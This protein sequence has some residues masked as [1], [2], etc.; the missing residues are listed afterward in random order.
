MFK[1]V[2]FFF[3]LIVF[4][5]SSKAEVV[6]EIIVNGNERISDDTVIMFTEISNGKFLDEDKLNSILKNLYD[7]GFFKD[8]DISFLNNKLVIKIVENPIIESVII[9]GIKAKKIKEPIIQNLLLKDRSSFNKFAVKKDEDFIIRFLKDKGYYF[10]KIITSI[11]DLG[12]NKISLIY[13]VEMGEKAKISKITFLGNKFFKD[14]KLRS[15]IITEEYKFWKFI[16]GKKFLNQG[17]IEFDKT[18]LSNFYKNEGFYKVKIDSTYANYLGGNKF[19]LIYNINSG[20]KFYFNNLSLT[21]PD[22]FDNTNFQTLN[23]LLKELNGKVY[24]INSIDKILKE[25]DKV[26]INKQ[27]EFTKSIVLE[28]IIDDKINLEFKID[29]TDKKYV[30]RI[31]IFGNDVTRETVIRDNFVIDEGDAFN[32]LL[33]TKSINNI[34]ALNFFSEVK[35]EVLDGS[36]NN[37]K[38][39]N[40]SVKEK[41]TGEISAGAGVGTNG[42]TLGFSV[43]ENNFLGKGI[44]FGSDLSL[45]KETIKG[46]FLLRNPNYQGTGRSIDLS[47]ESSETDRLKDFGYKSRKVGLSAGT[48]IELYEDLNLNT[49]FSSYVESLK[50]DTTAS[51]NMK[52][53]KGSYFDTYFNYS[54]VYDKRNQRFKTSEG[55]RSK[56]SQRIPI[57]SDKNSLENTYDYKLYTSWLEKSLATFGF[58]L[59]SVN[60]LTGDDVKLSERIFI[61]SSKLRGFEHGRVG[62]KD[63]A[64]Y[65]GGNYAFSFNAATSVPTIFPNSQSTDFSLFFDAANVWGVD[66]SSSLDSTSKIRSAIGIAVDWY[67]PLGP[68][69]F[70]LSQPVTKNSTDITESFRFNLGTTF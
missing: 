18:L 44:E 57:I 6:N 47:L 15:I 37:Q 11:N 50:T 34:K 61:P 40:I 69:N 2:I 43:K 14:S 17:L 33:H 23:S 45:S 36:T 48:G 56:F 16:S 22:D 62:P 8:V 30:E 12:D 31:N 59:S 49:G 66:Y 46:L 7:T 60:S 19:E 55:Y 38:I 52:K 3:L 9:N 27:Y 25:I 29:E 13:D 5:F 32:E 53:Q 21:I 58:F 64:D 63:G 68:L 70:S 4:N 67:T 1:Y 41:P 65:I 10:S 26:T 54:L 20:D 42:G 24:S 51:A 39:I 35:S 28:N